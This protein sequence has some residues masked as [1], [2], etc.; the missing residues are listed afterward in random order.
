M[1]PRRSP[2]ASRAIPM[3]PLWLTAH[4][5]T[6]FKALPSSLREGWEVRDETL[7]FKDSGEQRAARMS[8]MRLHDPKLIGFREE[9]QKLSSEELTALIKK[10]DLRGVSDDDIGELFFALGP[11]LLTRIL[12]SMLQSATSDSDLDDIAA[13][14]TVRHSLLA[15]FHSRS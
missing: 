11:D 5:Q 4:E 14:I 12:D 3:Q 15:S 13:M 10:T 7:T 2:S 1:S 9:A 6:L 8:L